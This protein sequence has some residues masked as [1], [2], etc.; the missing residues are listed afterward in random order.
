MSNGSIFLA[1]KMCTDS[2]EALTPPGDPKMLEKI[3]FGV[4]GGWVRGGRPAGLPIGPYV[5]PI[6]PVC[7]GPAH[8][9][10]LH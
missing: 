9:R 2:L 3:G 5:G 8:E 6:D 7:A 1:R 4:R 10:P